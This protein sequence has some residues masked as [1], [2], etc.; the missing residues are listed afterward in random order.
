[1]SCSISH[2]HFQRAISLS[3]QRTLLKRTQMHLEFQY[4]LS[5]KS[6]LPSSS[7]ERKLRKGKER[8][9]L[10]KSESQ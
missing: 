6:D 3:N 1:M 9:P 7:P 2:S 10:L 8:I 4:S 5:V